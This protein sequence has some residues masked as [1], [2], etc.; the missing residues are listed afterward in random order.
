MKKIMIA[1]LLCFI[2]QPAFALLSPLNQSLE[3]INAIVQS[4]DIEKRIPQNQSIQQI[5]RTSNGY[6]LRTNELQMQV[7]IQYLPS[8]YPGRQQFSLVF[9]APIPLTP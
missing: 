3:E 2:T 6:L 1:A 9:H 8:T 5:H 4:S 7:N